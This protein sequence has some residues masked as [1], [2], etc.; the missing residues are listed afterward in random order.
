[1]VT[2]FAHVLLTVV[3]AFAISVPVVGYIYA[4]H[5]VLLG[6]K[7]SVP[8]VSLPAGQLAAYQ[9]YASVGPS[10]FVV[11]AYDDLTT[12]PS[13]SSATKAAKTVSATA[14]A[15][16]LAMLRAAGFASVTS[17]QVSAY[18][19]GRSALPK[20]AVLIAFD[21]GR[22]R[23]WTVAYSLLARYD[24]TGVAFID[25]ALVA[26][27]GSGNLSWTQLDQMTSS[28]RW[29]VALDFSNPA[30]TIAIDAAGATGPALLEHA[31][32]PSDGR[33]E[34]TDEFQ[35]RVRNTLAGEIA[36][37]ANHGLAGPRLLMYPFDPTYPL[38]R[39]QTGFA[40]LSTVV[41]SMVG[42]GLLRVSPDA[43]VTDFYRAERLLPTLPVFSTTTTDGLFARI[44][45]A[46]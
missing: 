39:V 30:A 12:H 4:H 41:N 8:H 16:Q 20:H 28:G 35:A 25:P 14:F 29:S 34:T 40:E 7:T 21:G 44:G 33:T 46:A 15:K 31:W 22:V 23:D 32:L 17:D 6:G 10:T 13:A 1:V 2:R 18:L 27:R 38:S 11:L 36:D 42:A 43:A 3:V 19:A 37:I 9:G 5:L 45:A 24:Y 26:G